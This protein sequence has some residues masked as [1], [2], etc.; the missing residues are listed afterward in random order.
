MVCALPDQLPTVL[1][2]WPHSAHAQQLHNKFF[3]TLVSY[4]RHKSNLSTGYCKAVNRDVTGLIGMF[5][6]MSS[7]VTQ[8]QSFR[9]EQ[10]SFPPLVNVRIPLDTH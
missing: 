1:T 8:L 4:K 2:W 5:S 7:I 3:L 6:A 10:N 9:H